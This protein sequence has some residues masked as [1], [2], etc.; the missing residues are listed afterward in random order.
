MGIIACCGE[1]YRIGCFDHCSDVETGLVA[2]KNG[3]HTIL[4]KS[5]HVVHT[6]L[7]DVLSIS[8][9]IIFSNELRESGESKFQIIDP[10][11]DIFEHTDGGTTYQ[12]FCVENFVKA[13]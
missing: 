4:Y 1:C 6:I 5:G 7:T 13:Q 10:D 2:A 8:D 3:V 12:W 9:E 11:G